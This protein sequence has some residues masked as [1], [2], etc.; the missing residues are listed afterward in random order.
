MFLSQYCMW[1][2]LQGNTALHYAVSHCNMEVVS[3][4]LDTGVCDIDKQ[5]RAGYTA[6]MLASLADIQTEQQRDVIHRLFDTGNINIKALQVRYSLSCSQNW[7]SLLWTTLISRLYR[8]FILCCCQPYPRPYKFRDIGVASKEGCLPIQDG[9]L[10]T[11]LYCTCAEV[12]AGEVKDHCAKVTCMCRG[13]CRLRSLRMHISFVQW[14]LILPA[15]TSVHVW[16]I[17]AKVQIISH[18]ES[19]YN[20]SYRSCLP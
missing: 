20:P 7:N 11:K 16:C 8:L 18:F 17:H 5:N 6:I 4:I 14:P 12:I 15:M 9:R 19:G 1:C 2:I 3:L 13:C 10:F